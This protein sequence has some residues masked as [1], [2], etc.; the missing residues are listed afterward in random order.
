MWWWGWGE[1]HDEEYKPALPAPVASCP[2]DGDESGEDADQE[3]DQHHVLSEP[4]ILGM[5]VIL[6]M[7][8]IVMM[9]MIIYDD[10]NYD[11]GKRG[12]MT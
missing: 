2:V 10:G 5:M 1:A 11:L 7:T 12:Q 4:D 8:M 6:M 3:Q 9:I